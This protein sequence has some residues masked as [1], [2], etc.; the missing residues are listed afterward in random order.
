MTQTVAFSDEL[1]TVVFNPTWGVPQSIIYKE[2]LPK[3]RRDP[4]YFD[5]IGWKV[6]APNGKVVKSRSVQ[7]WKFGKKIPYSIIQPPSDDNALGEVKFLFPNKHNIYMHDTPLKKLFKEQVRAFSHGCIRVEDPRTLAEHV[8][9]WDREK[10]DDMIASGANEEIKLDHP[11][12]VHLTYFTAW[13]DESGKIVFYADT[14]KRDKR[15]DKA[16]NSLAVALN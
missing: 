8:L 2:M 16:L 11:I 4:G 3:L 12:P 6:V 5:R 10:I 15:L 7:W 1:E 13:L 14:Y 9:G